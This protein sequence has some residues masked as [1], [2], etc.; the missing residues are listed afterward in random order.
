MPKTTVELVDNSDIIREATKE[1]I[2]R[3]LVAVGM[4]A[5]SR[6]KMACPVDTGRLRN[7]ITNAVKGDTV[8]I[9]TNVEYAVYVEMGTVHTPA[10]PYLRP[11]VENHV[12]SYRNIL[13][14]QLN[15]G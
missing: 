5:E 1:A 7:S 13:L 4:A 15:K 3:G 14:T 10:Q 12:D 9:G 6:A 2:E 11:A 8:Y